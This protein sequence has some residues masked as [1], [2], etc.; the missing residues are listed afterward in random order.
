MPALSE[1]LAKVVSLKP[2]GKQWLIENG[3]CV[4]NIVPGQSTLPFA[5]R[6]AFAQRRIARGEVVVPVPLIQLKDTD[7]L[8]IWEEV[9]DEFGDWIDVPVGKQL[10]LNYCFGHD[11]S[12]LLLC[13]ITNAILINHCSNRTKECGESG[14]NAEYN[15]DTA[16]D[17]DTA[18]WLDMTLDEIAEV[19]NLGETLSPPISL[20][21]IM[22][23]HP[24][25]SSTLL[26]GFLRKRD[27]AF[28]LKSS[29]LETLSQEKRFS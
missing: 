12:S 1:A 14:P 18:R 7:A 21:T 9:Q 6:G 17:R 8:L 10:L 4:D 24:S 5:G 27:E 28:H 2:R 29:L 26:V 11:E 20:L 13:P 3:R 19:G 23:P 22:C 15:W 16:W 25:R